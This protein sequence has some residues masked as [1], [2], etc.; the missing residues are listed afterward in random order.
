M[1]S[2]GKF[3]S[4]PPVKYIYSSF[5]SEHWTPTYYGNK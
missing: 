3:D 5:L 2:M 4:C 1:A